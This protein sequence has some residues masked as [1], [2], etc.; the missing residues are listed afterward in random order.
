MADRVT[1]LTEF[2]DP[3]SAR[4]AHNLFHS[5]RSSCGAAA[6]LLEAEVTSSLQLSDAVCPS[7]GTVR[8]SGSSSCRV[9][10]KI[11]STSCLSSL[12]L[13]NL[14]TYSHSSFFVITDP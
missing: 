3:M 6:L 5:C 7:L 10:E 9:T 14:L 13:H 8:G 2:P 12:V 11:W 1:D 4:R